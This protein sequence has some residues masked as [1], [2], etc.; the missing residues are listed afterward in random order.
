MNLF[1][2]IV[3][4]LSSESGSLTDALLKTKVLLHKIGHKELVSWVD[5]ELSGYGRDKE[6][7]PYRKLRGRLVGDICNAIQTIPRQHLPIS[8]LPKQLAASVKE[9]GMKDS[10]RVLEKY[11]RA[12]DAL[13]VPI[14]PEL[15]QYFTNGLAAGHWVERAMI[16]IEP[17]QVLHSIT[18]IRTRL[19][20]FVLE[21]QDNLGDT[22]ESNMKEQGMKLDASALFQNAVIGNNATFVIGN[23]NTTKLKHSIQKGNFSSLAQAL[24]G[25]GVGPS[26]IADLRQAIERDAQDAPGS[27]DGPA[28]RSWMKTMLGKV[29]DASWNIELGVAAG[30]LT[31]ALKA[32]YA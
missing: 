12:K 24:E 32:Y 26:E 6:L 20:S 23:N 11:A 17:T 4:L 22:S 7:P 28:V 30:V 29:V 8:H 13:G 15:N 31:E 16:Q 18:E 14:A 1:N 2:E 27:E 21:L 19:L 9:T 3:A 5:D 25:Q 10:I